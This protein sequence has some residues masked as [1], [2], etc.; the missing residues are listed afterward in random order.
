VKK[1]SCGNSEI[2]GCHPNC[3]QGGAKIGLRLLESLWT[4]IQI[5]YLPARTALDEKESRRLM[6]LLDNA[7]SL[8]T[9][10]GSRLNRCHIAI[11]LIDANAASSPPEVLPRRHQGRTR[12]LLMPQFRGKGR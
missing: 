3:S 6:D 11:T 12:G 9:R 7:V 1:K 2:S 10:T 8:M 4:S 5:H